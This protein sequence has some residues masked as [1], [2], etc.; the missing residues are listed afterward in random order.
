MAAA[1]DHQQ[2]ESLNLD[3]SGETGATYSATPCSS[4][5]GNLFWPTAIVYNTRLRTGH[6]HT[7]PFLLSIFFLGILVH[8]SWLCGLMITGVPEDGG[9]VEDGVSVHF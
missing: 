2:D 3:G 7:G 1:A 4:G 5:D 9:N 8:V 6:V